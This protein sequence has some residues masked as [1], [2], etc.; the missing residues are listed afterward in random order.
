MISFIIPFPLFV[1]VLEQY[2]SF[3][4]ALINIF[5]PLTMNQITLRMCNVIGVFVLETQGFY[6]H[7]TQQNKIDRQVSEYV[8]AKYLLREL[9]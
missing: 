8:Q 7:L 5:W 2:Q 1:I 9:V 3:K 6:T 4:A